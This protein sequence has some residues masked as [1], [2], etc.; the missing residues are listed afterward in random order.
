ME[1]IWNVGIVGC[2]TIAD[3]YLKNLQSLFSGRLQV[4]GLFNR[5]REKALLLAAKY[6]IPRCY[7]RYE[8]MLRDPDIHIVLNLTPPQAHA[9]ITCQALQHGKHVYS[10][11][12]LAVTA[13]EGRELIQLAAEKKLR[14]ACAPDVP[15]GAM[16]QTARSL[17]DNGAIGRVIGAT[18]N[19][20]KA[21]V[22]TWHPNPRFL[23]EPGAGPL[24]DMGPY[25]LAALLHL[26]GPFSAVTAMEARNFPVRTIASQPHRGEQIHVAV[27]TYVTALLQTRSGAL[28]SLLATFDVAATKLPYLELYGE[29][30]S[31]CLSDPNCFGGSLLL[32]RNGSAYQAVPVSFPYAENCRG[33]GLWEMV[34]SLGTGEK[35]PVDG[36][37]ALHI[38]DVMEGIQTSART[39]RRVDIAS[40]CPR[41]AAMTVS[42]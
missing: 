36:E 24:M 33:L 7:S 8:D 25:Y 37:Y 5:T 15:L 31:L 6:G 19:L 20:C 27:P 11:K 42:E 41:P 23:F 28:V 17:L 1:P 10:E 30:G 35:S 4:W 38:L 22:E 2:G 3:I 29:T 34:R 9:Q 26:I 39:G 32:S 14:L 13:A 12:P 40:D 21:G 16:V 18:A